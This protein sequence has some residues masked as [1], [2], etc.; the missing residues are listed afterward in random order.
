LLCAS[1]H[2]EADI[3]GLVDLYFKI[4]MMRILSSAKVIDIAERLARKII[5]TYSEPNK[6]FIRLRQTINRNSVN[7]MGEFSI[8]CRE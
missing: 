6:R 2:E 8:A 1:Q 4:D 7:L 5:D 3:P